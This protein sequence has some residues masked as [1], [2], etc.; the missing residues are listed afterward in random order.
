MPDEVFPAGYIRR[1]IIEPTA[2]L[3]PT[4]EEVSKKPTEEAIPA[5]ALALPEIPSW[6]PWLVTGLSLLFATVAVASSRKKEK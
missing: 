6:I 3:F 1:N 5:V 2:L 4:P